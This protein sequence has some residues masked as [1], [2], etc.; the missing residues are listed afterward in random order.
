MRKI[1]C[2]G[3]EGGEVRDEA[4]QRQESRRAQAQKLWRLGKVGTASKVVRMKSEARANVEVI[5]IVAKI[6]DVP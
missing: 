4:R 2:W 3:T 5:E 6:A 1:G